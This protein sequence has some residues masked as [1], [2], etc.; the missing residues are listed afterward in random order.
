MYYFVNETH[1]EFCTFNDRVPVYE[2]LKRVIDTWPKWV[3]TDR[4]MIK[5][6]DESKSCDLWDH[7]TMNL[8]YKDLDYAENMG[9]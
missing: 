7:L 5:G 3:L 9:S 4:I 1:K 8:N 6:Q 2:D